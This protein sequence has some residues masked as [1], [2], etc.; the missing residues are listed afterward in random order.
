MNIN[1]EKRLV[2]SNI[3]QIGSV[4]IALAAS[5]VVCALLLLTAGADIW[6]AF[7]A[8][9][10]GAFGDWRATWKTLIK[11]TPLILTGVAVSVAFRAR[12]WNIGAEGQLYAGAMMSYWLYTSVGP[13]P[14]PILIPLLFVAG[15]LGGGLCGGL[16]GY[17]SAKYRVN[18]ILTTVM[19][20]YIIHYLVS[21]LL[22]GPWRD[23]SQFVLQSPKIDSDALLPFVLPATRLHLGF[24]IAVAVAI[25]TYFVIT[26]SS[27]GYEIRAVGMNKLAS[28]FK[29]IRIERTIITA[30]L[31]S[32]AV[33]GLA[34]VIEVFGVHARMKPDISLGFGFTGIII[35]VIALLNPIAVI[36]VAI[37]FGGFVNGGIKLQVATG[38]PSTMTDAIQAIILIFFL[39]AAVLARYKIVFEAKQ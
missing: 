10:D 33:A 15:A 34:G 36:F 32:G 28:R 3:W 2:A 30:M 37:L 13:L 17:L 19:M 31:I 20:N 11:A 5:G 1:I 14:L 7:A 39:T 12:I 6:Q 21:Y 9:W 18:E 35:A 38:V 23:P 8:L 4:V 26:K 22:V 25:I 24:P 16:A 27:L 29:G